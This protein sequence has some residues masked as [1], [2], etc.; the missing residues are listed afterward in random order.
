MKRKSIL[1]LSLIALLSLVGCGGNDDSSSSPL[2]VPPSSVPDDPSSPVVPPSSVPDVPAEI[3]L[4]AFADIL[5]ES[6]ANENKASGFTQVQKDT[7]EGDTTTITSKAVYYEELFFEYEEKVVNSEG[8]NTTVG[9]IGWT[10]KEKTHYATWSSN[11]YGGRYF[12]EEASTLS[13]DKLAT[14]NEQVQKTG[15]SAAVL[16]SIL[17]LYPEDADLSAVKLKKVS[18]E[19]TTTYQFEFS[20]LVVTEYYNYWT[21]ETIETKFDEENFL[22]D[23]TLNAEMWYDV[24]AKPATA[25][26]EVLEVS[27]SV[28][29]G[30]RKA[31]EDPH[32]YFDPSVYLVS[33]DAIV[34]IGKEVDGAFVETNEFEVG[35]ILQIK[36]ENVPATVDEVLVLSV[37]GS[38]SG[39]S[40]LLSFQADGVYEVIGTGTAT[41]ELNGVLYD[42]APITVTF[43]PKEQGGLDTLASLVV[44]TWIND[45]KFP[46]V[47]ITFYDDGTGE[48]VDMAYPDYMCFFTWE[49]NEETGVLTITE[50]LE[51][52]DSWQDIVGQ[53]LA[54]AS[55][56]AEGVLT[57]THGSGPFAIPS[58][59]TKKA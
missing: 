25:A 2:P 15:L 50:D 24:D 42:G 41:L 12:Y 21:E 5:N 17:E 3:T 1:T 13:E 46:G 31:F 30:A 29:K 55:I 40:G 27:A 7:Y 53:K 32:T 47:E 37:N 16:A 35:D 34:K 9:L 26:N 6:Y 4:T 59:W 28:E 11:E 18:G 19:S 20:G 22:L 36:V 43:N 51:A 10:T 54:S 52:G 57:L 56:S 39:S 48:A 8:E 23:F 38:A 49:V 45:A 14:Y 33:Q 44:G 58:D